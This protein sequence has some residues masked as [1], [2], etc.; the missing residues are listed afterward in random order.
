MSF[1]QYVL[2]SYIFQKMLFR[3]YSLKNNFKQEIEKK[4]AETPMNNVST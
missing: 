4:S 3:N 1:L 2:F